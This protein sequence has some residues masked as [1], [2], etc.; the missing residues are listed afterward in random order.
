[1]SYIGYKPDVP[2]DETVSTA[3]L[4]DGAVTAVKIA[5][6]AVDGTKI[7]AD[8]IDSDHYVDGSVDNA[9]LATGIDAT[10]LTSGTVADARISTLT[11]SKLTGALPAISGASLTGLTAVQIEKSITTNWHSTTTSVPSDNT[12]FTSSHGSQIHDITLTPTTT[13]SEIL[14]M[15]W[16]NLGHSGA[17]TSQIGIFKNS[18][19]G[20]KSVAFNMDSQGN[21]VIAPS[22]WAVWFETSGSL[23]ARTY[24]MR[25]GPNAGTG[26]TSHR[27]TGQ[28]KTPQTNGMFAIEFA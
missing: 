3:K 20:A 14:V 10:K 8:A 19:T 2:G 22:T 26:Y 13:S 24:K 6:D 17:T 12:T 11:A 23:T 5:D 21:N 1:M 18:E 7:A 15:A 27:G 9:H 4:V 16:A 25:F 28:I